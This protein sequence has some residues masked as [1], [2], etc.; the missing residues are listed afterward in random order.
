MGIQLKRIVWD[1]GQYNCHNGYIGQAK[2]VS[3]VWDKDGYRVTAYGPGGV[4]AIDRADG[5]AAAKALA[6]KLF[7]KLIETVFDVS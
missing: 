1:N 5:I 7:Q 4:N 2:V 3:A 6:P